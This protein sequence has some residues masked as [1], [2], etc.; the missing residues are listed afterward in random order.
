[1]KKHTTSCG[2]AYERIYKKGEQPSDRAV[3]FFH[4]GGYIVGLLFFYRI[5]ACDL[6]R[7]FGDADVYLLDYKCAPEHQYPS[8]LNEAV[9]MW[10]ELTTKLGYSPSNILLGGDSA[11]A[12]LMLALMLK[13]R[14]DGKELPSAAFG[15]S[16]WADMTGSGKSLKYNYGKD[17]LFGKLGKT[18]SEE[19][20]I[21]SLDGELYS[22]VGTADRYSPYVSPVY[23]EFE[24]FPTMFFTVGGDE[25]LLDDTLRLVEKLKSSSVPVEYDVQPKMFHV[26]TLFGEIIPESKISYKKLMTFVSDR[27]SELSKKGDRITK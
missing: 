16:P 1:M 5:L 18:L 25:I 11:G 12:N 3:C 17:V 27:Y 22:F 10:N 20:R 4:G 14:D 21:K 24:G 15:I 26:Y 2:T 9:D 7:A 8:Q 6:S 13:L 23:G 19:E